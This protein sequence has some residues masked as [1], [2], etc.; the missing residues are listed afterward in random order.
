[1]LASTRGLENHFQT[2]TWIK[3][4]HCENAR[5]ALPPPPSTHTNTHT[6]NTPTT[7]YITAVPVPLKADPIMCP[8]R[9]QR[10]APL[11]VSSQMLTAFPKRTPPYTH[12]T[13]NQGRKGEETNIVPGRPQ[14][15]TYLAFGRRGRLGRLNVSKE[16]TGRLDSS[17]D[18][19][20][21]KVK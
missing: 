13:A 11:E 4:W 18:C 17:A 12:H 7:G 8:E 1:M 20:E 10:L 14:H 21:M 15:P 2:D 9:C 3:Y 16:K 5:M 6:H 19:G